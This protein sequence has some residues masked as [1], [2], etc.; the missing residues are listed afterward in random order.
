MG[1]SDWV[2]YARVAR[3]ERPRLLG[4]LGGTLRS[5][6]ASV[7]LPFARAV[8]TWA[9]LQGFTW[10]RVWCRSI[11]GIPS[12]FFVFLSCLESFLVCSRALYFTNSFLPNNFYSK[13]IHSRRISNYFVHFDWKKTSYFVLQSHAL[14]TSGARATRKVQGVVRG[15]CLHLN[16]PVLCKS[17]IV[18][19]VKVCQDITSYTLEVV[20]AVGH[21]LVKNV[22]LPLGKIAREQNPVVPWVGLDEI[23]WSVNERWTGPD[24]RRKKLHVYFSMWWNSCSFEV[25]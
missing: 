23:T 20:F 5:V 16:S 4:S 15:C 17:N 6:A 3:A 18:K 22:V 1:T 14:S 7:A 19:V 12:I 11:K 13:I 10:T 8:Q 2:N 9:C 21:V 25:V 24:G